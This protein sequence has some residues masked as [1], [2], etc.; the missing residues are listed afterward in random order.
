MLVDKQ[1]DDLYFRYLGTEIVK[2]RN[3]KKYRC[4]KVS[5]YL[6]QG[7]FFPEGEYMKIWFTDDRNHVPVQV[8][9]EILIGSVKALLLETKSL[10]YPLTSLI[11]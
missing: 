1:V 8:E 7:D 11:N 2:T 4:Q 10:K 3:G 5:V 9:T 6:L